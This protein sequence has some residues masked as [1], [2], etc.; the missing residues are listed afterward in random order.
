MFRFRSFIVANA[1][2]SRRRTVLTVASIAISLCLLTVLAAMY[3][4]LFLEPEATPSEA[5]RLVTHHRVSI[6]QPMP[7]SFLTTIRNLPGVRDTMIWQWFGG[8]YRDARDA[9]NFF[10]RF[11]VEP[12]RF[13]TI[14]P[15]VQLP[16]HEKL[17]FQRTRS[18][19]IVGRKLRDRFQWKIG[20][21]IILVGDIYP[22]T[23]E[24]TLAGV[25][26]AP[27]DYE[28]LYFNYE[29]LRQLLLA[30]GQT[31]RV[32]KVGVFL[33]L[34]G[35]KEAV[36]GVAAAIDKQFEDSPAPTK[37]ESESAWQLS[38]ISFLGN[39]KLFLLSIS[40]ALVFTTLLVSGNTISM[41]IR[42]RTREV[43]IL[44]TLGF[45]EKMILGI[46]MGETMLIGILGGILGILLGELLATGVRMGVAALGALRLTVTLDV[47]I[48]MLLAS[49]A[50]AAI[51]SFIP[52][53]NASRMPILESLR[54]FG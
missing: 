26:S 42:E 10:A 39:L 19:C 31:S 3:R 15:E 21:R 50:M 30:A 16:D 41:T 43:G 37:S 1:L 32:D 20:D 33:T 45:T 52:A 38:F 18:G 49:A 11:A 13:F 14:K 34:A 9:R 46:F 47:A 53:R 28:N 25:Y 7:V 6:T 51:S 40:G 2:R 5:L 4:A 29:Y 48:L 12:E 22:V 44:K 24:L 27:E 36:D 17:A 35:R 8:S 54:S 23:L